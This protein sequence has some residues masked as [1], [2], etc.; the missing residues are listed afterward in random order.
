MK[1]DKKAINVLAAGD[2]PFLTVS[3][4]GRNSFWRYAMGLVIPFL[5]ANTIGA[6][7]LA[8]LLFRHT[9][10]DGGGQLKGSMPDFEAMGIDP[11][12][13]FI[14]TMLPFIL[15]LL[16]I[17]FL[18]KPLHQ[19]RTGTV[20]N[21]GLK[22]R[23]GRMFIS[24]LLWLVI[25]AGWLLFTLKADPDNF[26]INND[27][28]SLLTFAVAALLLIPLQ[29]AFEEV[30]FR[31]YLMQGFAVMARNRWV[32]LLL[33]S[34]IF[35]LMHG[36]NP[37]VQEFG[38][39]TMMPQY[40]FFGLV[41]GITTLFDE[42]VEMAIG[43]HAANN[44]FLSVLVTNKDSALQTPARYEQL[45]IDPWPEF[46]GLV[47]MSL[48]FLVIMAVIY[49]WKD[50]RKLYARVNPPLISDTVDAG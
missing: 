33:T 6:I 42:G 25:S 26:R 15:G 44:L 45:Q 13:G 38:F 4:S 34:L 16:T 27:S 47:I 18:I 28:L 46:A 2:S 19:R 9:M 22:F 49:R 17:L 1:K 30:L 20:I 12:V 32:P 14:V 35:G 40:I 24:A 5:A 37:E 29:A 3:F 8:I 48:L 39:L 10:A 23:W 36:L 7:P 43:A 41:F 11:V 50:L 31:G 21:G